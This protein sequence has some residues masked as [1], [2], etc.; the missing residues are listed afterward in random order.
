SSPLDSSDRLPVGRGRPRA[1]AAPSIRADR[2]GGGGRQS[3]SISADLILVGDEPV[4]AAVAPSGVVPDQVEPDPRPRLLVLTRQ[5]FAPV[6]SRLRRLIETNA[7]ILHRL[8]SSYYRSSRR[9]A[10][11][12]SSRR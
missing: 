4:D 1:G 12:V 6:D 10:R 9:D 3:P 7:R 8:S 5:G 2:C 11:S